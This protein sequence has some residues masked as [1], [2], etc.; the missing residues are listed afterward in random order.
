MLPQAAQQRPTL[1]GHISALFSAGG[2]W[3]SRQRAVRMYSPLPR[4][5]YAEQRAVGMHP[6]YD[7]C[8]A[9]QRHVSQA[10]G[11]M[12]FSPVACPGRSQHKLRATEWRQPRAAAASG[13]C[14]G[15]HPPGAVSA[16]VEIWSGKRAVRG[17]KHFLAS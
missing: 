4:A 13:L 1:A 16:P 2:H 12:H 10:Q 6:A 9:S 5:N 8:N 15:R 11:E 3:S 17:D 7:T 14:C